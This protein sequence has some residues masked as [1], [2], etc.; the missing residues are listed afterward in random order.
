MFRRRKPTQPTKIISP[1]SIGTAMKTGQATVTLK[2]LNTPAA[3]LNTFNL[4]NSVPEE[5]DPFA[6]DYS[7]Y[8][9]KLPLPPDPFALK[10]V[11]PKSVRFE[12]EQQRSLSDRNGDIKDD[13]AAEVSTAPTSNQDHGL[14]NQ[15]LNMPQVHFA[16]SKSAVSTEDGNATDDTNTKE[17]TP[18]EPISAEDTDSCKVLVSD[19]SQESSNDLDA[20]ENDSVASGSLEIREFSLKDEISEIPSSPKRAPSL[21]IEG[22]TSLCPL[23]LICTE[24]NPL[25]KEKY[26]RKNEQN[27][28][29]IHFSAFKSLDHS[30]F[31]RIAQ[32]KLLLQPDLHLIEGFIALD[33]QTPDPELESNGCFSPINPR[34]QDMLKNGAIAG[35]EDL[36]ETGHNL[37]VGERDNVTKREVQLNRFSIE[38]LNMENAALQGRLEVFE[39]QVEV[40]QHDCQLQE[41]ESASLREIKFDSFSK[42]E[43]LES[44]IGFQ[45]QN[46]A[47]LRQELERLTKENQSIQNAF[48]RQDLVRSQEIKKAPSLEIKQLRS[49]IAIL[50]AQNNLLRD[51][52]EAEIAKLRSELDI[53]RNLS[54]S[55]QEEK[56]SLLLEVAALTR[57]AAGSVKASKEIKSEVLMLQEEVKT[58]CSITEIHVRRSMQLERNHKEWVSYV[59]LVVTMICECVAPIAK[60]SHQELFQ[61]FVKAFEL[62]FFPTKESLALRFLFSAAIREIID[63]CVAREKEHWR[64]RK[65]LD[66]TVEA[67]QK[68]IARHKSTE[69]R[70]S[71]R[72]GPGERYHKSRCSC[73]K[74]TGK[75]S[76][77]GILEERTH[78]ID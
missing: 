29:M 70:C 39:K 64:V 16:D 56:D 51:E 1:A 42:L 27:Q 28:K 73:K 77:C 61:Y 8:A 60:Q 19:V 50:Q 15:K 34:L 22:S 54:I 68:K 59:G 46:L 23:L 6:E 35:L 67:L 75:K 55:L 71:A 62:G 14:S 2:T 47:N 44:D 37:E 78:N 5:D 10:R 3:L 33:T 52:T 11:R 30:S 48:K 26:E 38:S 36:N 21:S 20:P 7:G 17:S 49:Q 76:L 18:E 65:K 66:Q 72:V 12:E 9:I 58:A 74:L 43:R 4:A 13:I 24:G 63:D 40:M 53:Q 32:L 25:H 69:L 31:K 41:E 45:L 57:D